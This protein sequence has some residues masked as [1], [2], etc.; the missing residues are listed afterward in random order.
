M[1]TAYDIKSGPPAIVIDF[2]VWTY[3]EDVRKWAEQKSKH[4]HIVF[5]VADPDKNDYEPGDERWSEY[6]E[7]SMV[8]RNSAANPMKSLDFKT[9]A[10]SAIQQSSTLVPVIAVE[11]DYTVAKHF[12]NAGVLEV[13]TVAGRVL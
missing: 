3:S 5:F 7:A 2:D 12:C 1:D 10:L 13:V 4:A 8:I 11:P 9:A 6:H